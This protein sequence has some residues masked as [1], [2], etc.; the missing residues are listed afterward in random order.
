MISALNAMHAEE[1]LGAGWETDP[2]CDS[3][4]E[5]VVEVKGTVGD[6]LYLRARKQFQV[7]NEQRKNHLIFGCV[8]KRTYTK[9]EI[10]AAE[11]FLV[12]SFTTNMARPRNTVPGTPM[13]RKDPTVASVAR[14]YGSFSFLHSSQ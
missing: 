3:L 8:I 7:S 10:E 9:K 2:R 6:E 1:V 5:S 13:H 14:S 12:L 4:S 11:L